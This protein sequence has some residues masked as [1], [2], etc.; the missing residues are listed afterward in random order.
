MVSIVPDEKIQC[1]LPANETERLEA[2]RSYDILDSQPEVDFDALT[3]V[4][5]HTFNTPVAVVGLMDSDRLWFKSRL[6][7][8]LPQLDRQ[9]AFCAFAIMQ[10]GK[11]LVVE[12]LQ[13]DPRFEHNPLVTQPPHVRFYAGAPLVDPRGFALGTI[14]VV[15]TK[16]R[17]IDKQE[18]AVLQD[19]AVLVMTALENRRRSIL[20]TQLALTD[21]LTGIANRAQFDR[22]LETEMAHA[23]RSGQQFSVLCMDLDGF[24]GINDRYGHLAGDEVLRDVTRRLQEQLRTEDIVSRI[25]GDEFGIIIRAG[26]QESAEALSERI[27]QAMSMPVSLTGGEKI[28]IGISI[29]MATY[30]DAIDSQHTLMAQADSA[31]YQAKRRAGTQR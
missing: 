21:Y 13:Q 2:V 11:V 16:P 14:A 28:G 17:S 20:L 23:K 31:L 25:G 15:D 10:P 5:A 6:G 27:N 12:D 19:L 29:G 24:K 22:A 30:S 1:P 26:S 9:I 18:E 7:L 8:E 4:A 3:R